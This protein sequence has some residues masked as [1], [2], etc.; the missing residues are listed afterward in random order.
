MNRGSGR[1]IGLRR[2]SQGFRPL[3]WLGVKKD[4][5]VAGTKDAGFAGTVS[6]EVEA[7]LGDALDAV[8]P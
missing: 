2:I 3:R 1:K 6:E 7:C 4:V 8:H 5:A